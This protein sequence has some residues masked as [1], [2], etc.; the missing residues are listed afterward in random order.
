MKVILKSSLLLFVALAV[1]A[2]SNGIT[3]FKMV[4]G[5][6]GKEVV[7]LNQ[8]KNCCSEEKNDGNS[9]EKKCCDFSAQTFKVSLLQK[10]ESKTI[11]FE[12]APSPI[13]FAAPAYISLI[14][15]EP[16]FYSDIAPPKTGR[17][18]RCF[19]STYII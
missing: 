12:L 15:G 10:T 6:S 14:L 9:F 1:L 4:C 18:I 7:S 16:K 19:N 11:G 3:L 5:S 17:Q 8:I 13:P 2:S